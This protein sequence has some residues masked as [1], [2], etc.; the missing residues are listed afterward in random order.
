[1]LD[2]GSTLVF[3]DAKGN[4]LADSL[5]NIAVTGRAGM[6]LLVPGFGETL[7]VNDGAHLNRNPS[8]PARHA[9]D[10]TRPP[11]LAVVVEVEEAFLHY[12]AAMLRSR[13][14]QPDA[15][16][17]LAGLASAAQIWKATP[18]HPI[19]STSSRQSSPTATPTT[20]T[21]SSPEPAAELAGEAATAP[22]RTRS[23]IDP[24][25]LRPWGGY[26]GG[27]AAGRLQPWGLSNW[28]FESRA[29]GRPPQMRWQYPPIGTGRIA[30]PPISGEAPSAHSE[31]RLRTRF[32]RAS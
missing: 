23:S 7:G 30:A 26:L 27:E 19:P 3:G 17:D 22:R 32:K 6:L 13:L 24:R 21:G 28:P 12:A 11:K 15:W 14:W 1:M 31:P 18:P 25:R 4:R 16:P 5:R 20:S 9:G 29:I 2:D 8:I 10:G